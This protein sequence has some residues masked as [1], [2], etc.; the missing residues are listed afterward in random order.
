MT[1]R[2]T[3]EEEDRRKQE[4]ASEGKMKKERG[5][6]I[7]DIDKT[8]DVDAVEEEEF[9]E[10]KKHLRENKVPLVILQGFN[11]KRVAQLG[12]IQNIGGE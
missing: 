10:R 4:D 5:E 11:W 12:D 8:M 1:S 6:A 2:N 9:Q 3:G 7:G